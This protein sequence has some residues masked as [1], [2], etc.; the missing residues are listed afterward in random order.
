MA[1]VFLNSENNVSNR[2][3]ELS[4]EI[5]KI[6]GY[7]KIA[8][9]NFGEPAINSGPC[10][11]FANAFFKLWN[12]KSTEKVNIVF[13]MVKN[14]DECWHTLIR[15]PNGLL[16]DGGCGVHDEKKYK[17][18]FDIEDMMEYNIELLEKRSYGLNREYPRYC[19][20]FSMDVI[21]D[22]IKKHLDI[23]EKEITFQKI[24]PSY[25]LIESVISSSIGAPTTEKIAKV[26]QGYKL[27]N[28]FLIG[29]F[30]LGTLIAII[31]FELSG[32]Q[33][34]IK[35]ISVLKDFRKQGIAKALIHRLIK[36]CAPNK[37]LLETDDESVGFY[38]NIGFICEP[39]VDK[40]GIRYRCSLDLSL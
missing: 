40:Y 30:S 34:T 14:S 2:L 11:P 29:A 15:L 24:S 35:H 33:A 25:S 32:T 8:G 4:D 21:T 20:T 10:G 6:Y 7:V 27:P 13:I 37:V 17:D 28:Q 18:R 1:L 19:P 16:F 23:I 12:Q 31:G 9:D 3:N 22:L 36:D 38:K 5:N 26:L 39:F